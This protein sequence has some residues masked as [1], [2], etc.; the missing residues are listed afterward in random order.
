MLIDWIVAVAPIAVVLVLML[1]FRWGADRAGFAGWI[2]ALALAFARFGAGLQLLALAQGKAVLLAAYVLYIVWMA[3]IFFRVLDEAGAIRSIGAGLPSLTSDRGLQ[4]LL[5]SWAF[6]SFLQG[7][8]GYGVPTAVVAPLLIGVGFPA[9]PAVVIAG[10]GHAWAVTFGSLAAS[11]QA[12]VAATGRAGPELAPMSALLLGLACFGCGLAVLWAAGGAQAV[13]GGLIPLAVIGLVMSGTQYGLAQIG[14]YP[15]AAVGAGLAGLLAAAAVIQWRNRA[16]KESP[17]VA[18]A[19]G[20]MMPLWLALSPYALLIVVVGAAQLIG[21]AQE[22]LDG[23]VIRVPFPEMRTA[24]GYVTPAETGRTISVF[25]HPGALLAYSALATFALFSRLGRYD[26]EAGRRIWRKTGKSALPASL[27]IL[28][29]VAMAVTMEHAGMTRRIAEGL[30]QWTGAAYPL[31]SPFIGALGAFMTGSNT[32]S[33]V[34]FASLQQNAAQLLALD[35]AVILAGQTTGGALG[36]AFAPAKVIVG[37]STV[38]LAG[39]EGPVL[40]A[41]ALYG[42]A[43]LAVVALAAA[44]IT[45]G[46]L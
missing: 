19:N 39:K 43:I 6:G 1:R 40:K 9:G 41:T 21:P 5:L 18:S 45:L 26:R 12:L 17:L 38:G 35:P 13:R 2:A 32:N 20:A 24:L 28:T 33:N 14:L 30:G 37:C 23:L 7:I 22:A 31:V 44:A 36:G 11:F 46:P 27:G 8:S 15:L 4:A 42:L 16:A 34:V 25:G 3:L 29:M 10:I